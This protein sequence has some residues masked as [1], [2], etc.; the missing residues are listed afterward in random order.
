MS[1]WVDYY[2][3]ED[4]N[5]VLVDEAGDEF[6]VHDE[7]GNYLSADEAQESGAVEFEGGDEIVDDRLSDDQAAFYGELFAE[8]H[9]AREIAD[10]EAW[11]NAF[12]NSLPRLEVEIG[13]TPTSAEYQAVIEHA[14]TTAQ[15]DAAL[16]YDE[17][18]GEFDASKTSHRTGRGIEIADDVFKA[19]AA[20]R[21]ANGD[22]DADTP[23]AE[24]DRAAEA[25]D[26]TLSRSLRAANAV[27]AGEDPAEAAAT[28]GSAPPP[29]PPA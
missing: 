12:T 5:L 8:G 18:V 25:G 20:M 9:S 3:D 27:Y 17:A 13:R 7:D 22:P 11:A 1:E 21:R 10:A 29:A 28:E 19:D 6:F 23:E 24:Q 14:L 15:P 2:E 4:G 16:S 26:N